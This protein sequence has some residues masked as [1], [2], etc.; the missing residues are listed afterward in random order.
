MQSANSLQIDE[1]L[2]RLIDA[3]AQASGI[4]SAELVRE[5]VEE[6]AA[7]R[8]GG[9]VPAEPDQ[10]DAAPWEIA[11]EIGKAVPEGEW[12]K[13]PEDLSRNFDHYHYGH[14]KRE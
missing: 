8:N 3:L 9:F 2:K 10:T 11:L 6:F 4:S 7:A 13:L 1:A 5:A 14:P 12:A